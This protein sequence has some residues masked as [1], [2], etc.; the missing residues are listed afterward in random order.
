MRCPKCRADNPD[1]NRFCQ[2]CGARLVVHCRD[3]GR[4]NQPRARFCGSC[5]SELELA[6]RRSSTPLD[7]LEAGSG[8][9][10]H[11]TVLFADIVSS[12]EL[13]ARLDPEQAMVRLK[14][15]VD[16]MCHAVERYGG[17]VIQTLGDGIMALF[18]APR[19]LEG[20]AFLACEA[21]LTMRESIMRGE[22][23]LAIRVGLH[24]GDVL[25]DSS[26]ANERHPGAHG[27][28]L[29]LGS[30]VVQ[31]AEPGGICLSEG[32]HRLV[33]PYYDF[34]PL[35]RRV[36]K[37]V[38]E[39][40]PIYALTVA[41]PIANNQ[42]LHRTYLGSFHGRTQELALLQRAL[43][44]A[45]DSNA[46]AI[47][48]VGGTG[49]GK[50]RLC[51]EFAQWCY[52]RS[53]RVFEV[54]A[55]LH[56]HATPL[57]PVLEILRSLYFGTSPVDDAA[58]SRQRV[59]E[60]LLQLGPT[61]V[62]DLPIVW[63]FLG[64]SPDSDGRA[65]LPA[66]IRRARLLEIMRHLVRQR[67]TNTSVIIINDMH[68]LDEASE[69]FISALVE[70]VAG[71]RTMVV[72][73][74]RPSYECPWTGWEHFREI[75][76]AELTPAEIE[77]LVDE[78]IG[79]DPSVQGIRRQ[80]AERSGGNPFFAEELVRALAEA[81]SL[82]GPAGDYR[83]G[84]AQKTSVLPPTVHV[85]IA[86]RIDHLDQF[87]K[88]VL[89]IAAII[90]KRIPITV[91]ERLARAPSAAVAEA[92]RRL[93]GNGLLQ[94]QRAND[95]TEYAFRHPLFQEVAYATQT[96][97]RRRALHAAVAAAMEQ[98]YVD[99]PAELAGL[100]AY[101]YEAAAQAIPAAQ[102]TARAAKWIGA[103]S[104]R[105]A[106]RLWH[107]VI[108]LL[109]DQ[110]PSPATDTLLIMANAQ[111]A[112]LGWREGMTGSAAEPFIREAVRIARDTDDTMIPLLLF[113]E[114]RISGASGG[115]ADAYVDVVRNALS[116][117]N[118]QSHIV[119]AA[120]LNAS[121]S[122]A[123]GWA[124]LFDQ[125]L[126]ANDTAMAALPGSRSDDDQFLGYSVKHWILSLRA[127]ILVRLGRAEEAAVCSSQILDMRPELVDPTV[128][129]IAHLAYVEV[130][131][132]QNDAATAATHASR[133]S[134]L[135]ERHGS[136]YMRV[137][138][139][140]S[141]GVAKALQRDF[142]PSMD[143]FARSLEVIRST[144]VAMNY[145][146][147]VLAGLADCLFRSTDYVRAVTT[148]REAIEV[149]RARSARSPE[150]RALVTLGTALVATEGIA[151]S[152][153]AESLFAQAEQLIALTGAA[154]YR[155]LL[156][157]ARNS[158]RAA[159]GTMSN[160]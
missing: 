42:R 51:F 50:S 145:E 76:L 84:I 111:I 128:Q 56:G 140:A 83:L 141:E 57:Q 86:D 7:E 138:A 85:A 119:R 146:A 150:I 132:S 37:G 91:L 118:S 80:V 125:A 32:C 137:Y 62:A 127:R 152:A 116:L 39:P 108:Q 3:C 11:A 105:E 103:T 98:Q 24:S 129:F 154:I 17:S 155:H 27:F 31:F 160:Q 8:E 54:H 19:S 143:C 48:I 55:Q 93:S 36:L 159:L 67:G 151:R 78:L 4:E 122:Q 10:K 96:H 68:W 9:L 26:E 104:T 112:W 72:L 63:E 14:P 107:K 66:R 148:A 82:V 28:T 123:Y 38:P 58:M 121:L 153:D 144:K 109:Q 30:R 134:V 43:R 89:Q 114:A 52:S 6:S 101:H 40:V 139:L 18:G 124:G 49:V 74:Y 69:D 126:A 158:V 79:V 147:D 133:I 33:H 100:L 120:T 64:V 59:K 75:H 131:W 149:A 45:E 71:T 1:D 46:A 135:A 25:A 34:A 106:V 16:Q 12:T 29:H 22:A 21:A 90:G 87:D 77:A 92:L 2:T 70:S 113:V 44:Q 157:E 156:G 94:A 65:Q 5:G 88:S 73:N 81:G 20:H 13:V 130:A 142:A 23:G 136:A 99:G 97:A 61:F 15:A 53:I 60:C 102:H 95:G 47:G 110:E 41:K 35:G 117:I 115:P